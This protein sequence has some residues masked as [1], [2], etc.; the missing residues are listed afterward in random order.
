LDEHYREYY[1]SF[2]CYSVNYKDNLL[3]NL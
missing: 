1:N 2:N 3:G